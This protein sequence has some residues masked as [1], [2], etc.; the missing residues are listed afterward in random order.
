M[1]SFIKTLIKPLLV[2]VLFFGGLWVALLS[3]FKDSRLGLYL[4]VALIP[5]PNIWYK[6]HGYEF[7]KDYF[8]IVFLAIL[9]GI[10]VQRLG[11]V[12][13]KNTIFILTLILISYLALWNGALNFNLPMPISTANEH[14]KDWKNYVQMIFLYFFVINIIKTEREQKILIIIVCLVVFFISLRSFRN[15]SGGT[16]FHWDKRDGGPFEVVGLGANH[17]GAFIAYC[18]TF[19]LGLFWFEKNKIRK[20]LYLFTYLLGLHPLL[21]SYSRGAYLASLVGLSFFGRKKKILLALVLVVIAGYQ[22][23]LP[24]SVV[25]RIKMTES[26]S[27]KLDQSSAHRLALWKIAL[28]A[29][30]QHPIFGIG[31]GAFKY[32]VPEGEHLTDT[33]NYFIK[34]ICE[35]GIIGITILLLTLFNAFRSGSLLFKIGHNDFQKGVGFGFMGC[36]LALAVANMF[37][38]RFSY[39]PLGGYFWILW[40]LVDRGVLI[41][42]AGPVVEQEEITPAV[43]GKWDW[44]LK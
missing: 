33:H 39:F 34:T 3:V 27:G 41:S 43:P 21:F 24:A 14:L 13:T 12:K 22:I 11:F 42:Q 25:D 29:Y 20:K 6:F 18:I 37:G 23:F 40:G 30:Q 28:N 31:F 5:Q 9:M 4:F 17:F 38:D 32:I 36:V 2:P 7:G 16:T 26:S 19:F 44:L 1:L 35:Q 10:F 8:D 15:F